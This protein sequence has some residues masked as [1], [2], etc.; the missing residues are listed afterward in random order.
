MKDYSI[1]QQAEEELQIASA[2]ISKKY[3]FDID[4]MLIMNID[5]CSKSIAALSMFFTDKVKDK[6]AEIDKFIDK[7]RED[8]HEYMEEYGKED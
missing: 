6:H 3:D 8:V 4:D 5:F 1:I 2:E 7:V